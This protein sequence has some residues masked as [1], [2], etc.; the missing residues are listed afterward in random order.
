MLSFTEK[1]IVKEKKSV[2]CRMTSVFF[3]DGN[4]CTRTFHPQTHNWLSIICGAHMDEEKELLLHHL[5]LLLLVPCRLLSFVGAS[6]LFELLV[7]AVAIA[8]PRILDAL[9]EAWYVFELTYSMSQI[10]CMIVFYLN[11]QVFYLFRESILE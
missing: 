9:P 11:L 6:L 7:A 8:M 4:P 5:R 1:K 2:S 10:E 3:L